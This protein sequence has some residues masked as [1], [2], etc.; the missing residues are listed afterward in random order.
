MIL[1]NL[2]PCKINIKGGI[3]IHINEFHMTFIWNSSIPSF[4]MMDVVECRM[5][6][7]KEMGSGAPS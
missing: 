7:W 5:N 1:T 4:E 6:L 3:D 2:K